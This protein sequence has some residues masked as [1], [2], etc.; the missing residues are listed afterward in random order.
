VLAEMAHSHVQKQLTKVACDTTSL[1]CAALLYPAIC[2]DIS[3]SSKTMIL[4]I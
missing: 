3:T 4:I 1:A 2:R